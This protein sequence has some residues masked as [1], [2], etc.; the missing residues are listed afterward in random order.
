MSQR[1]EPSVLSSAEIQIIRLGESSAS[2]QEDI[3]ALNDVA[4]NRHE[5]IVKLAIQVKELLVFLDNAQRETRSVRAELLEAQKTLLRVQSVIAPAPLTGVCTEADRNH[6]VGVNAEGP[7][8]M[9]DKQPGL[10]PKPWRKPIVE[11]QNVGFDGKEPKL[12]FDTIP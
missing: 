8:E 4:G 2:M 1:Y 6:I 3:R 12:G 5:R 10:T 7:V 9:L 11:A